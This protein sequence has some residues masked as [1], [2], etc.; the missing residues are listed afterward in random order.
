MDHFTQNDYEDQVF[1]NI[2]WDHKE[3]AGIS[4]LDCRFNNCSFKESTFKGCKFQGCVFEKCDLS[5]AQVDGSS[6]T[7]ACFEDSKLIGVNWVK[8]VWRK[9]EIQRVT[10]SIDF[11]RCAL[12]YS[13]FMGLTLEK[14]LLKKCVAREVD[15]SE[16]DLKGAICTFTD[17]ELSQFRHT[18]LTEADLRGALNYEIIPSLNT[19]KK[20]RFSLPEAL[21]LLYNLD[22][23][24]GEAV[25]EG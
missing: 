16:A 5:L 13:T 14:M 1:R 15:F 24:I 23:E 17:F 9:K 8:A 4:F 6:F 3:L 12:N 19:L 22:I 11:L 21:S 20:T 25:E 2:T 10:R 18:D 7:A